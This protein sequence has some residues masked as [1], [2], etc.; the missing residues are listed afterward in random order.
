MQRYKNH[1]IHAVA[2]Q[3][4]G[5][6]WHSRGSVFDPVQ[7]ATEI[8]RIEC[9]EIVCTSSEEAEEYALILCQAW[10]DGLRPELT[11]TH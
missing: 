6:L 10:I 4:R 8:K 1:P 2:V 7:P 5:A 9:G 3:R 11:T